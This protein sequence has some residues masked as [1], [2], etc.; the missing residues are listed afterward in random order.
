MAIFEWK[1]EYDTGIPEIDNQHKVLVSVINELDDLLGDDFDRGAVAQVFGKLKDYALYHFATEEGLMAQYHYKE[2]D[3][4]A[5]LTQ[6]RQFENEI[7]SVQSDFGNISVEDCEVVLSYLT[8]WLIYHI[9]KVDHRLADFIL[10]QQRLSGK[11]AFQYTAVESTVEI[12]SSA[13]AYLYRAKK[14]VVAADEMLAQLEQCIDEL[15]CQC[16][17]LAQESANSHLVSISQATFLRC[18]ESHNLIKSLQSSQRRLKTLLDHL[19]QN[20]T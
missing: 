11:N 7:E 5:H 14:H 18:T 16:D 6:H 8:N 1:S 4:Q 3:L 12:P 9:C 20:D 15:S 19:E 13:M 17:T 2:H 10:A